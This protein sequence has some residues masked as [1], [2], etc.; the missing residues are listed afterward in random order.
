MLIAVAIST[1]GHRNYSSTNTERERVFGSAMALAA[2]ALVA[3]ALQDLDYSGAALFD[4]RGQVVAAKS[5][6]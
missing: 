6:N 4:K 1:E 3:I 2:A 5:K